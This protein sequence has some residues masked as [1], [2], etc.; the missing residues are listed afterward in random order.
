[1]RQEVTAVGPTPASPT[2]PSLTLNLTA[3]RFRRAPPTVVHSEWSRR[4]APWAT[5]TAAL[6]CRGELI[7]GPPQRAE[8][9]DS[10]ELVI[11]VAGLDVLL[12]VIVIAASASMTAGTEPQPAIAAAECGG[13]GGSGGCGGSG[14]P[15]GSGGSGNCRGLWSAVIVVGRGGSSIGLD[16]WFSRGRSSGSSSVPGAR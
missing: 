6:R 9:M 5:L 11:V 2:E 1:M 16:V 12:L 3:S 13:G 15:G 7:R 10:P 14:G 8:S 4:S